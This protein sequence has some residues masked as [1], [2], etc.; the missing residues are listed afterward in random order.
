MKPFWAWTKKIFFATIKSIYYITIGWL[1][2]IFKVIKTN[3]NKWLKGK[4]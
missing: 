1:Y 2:L 3:I 4:K